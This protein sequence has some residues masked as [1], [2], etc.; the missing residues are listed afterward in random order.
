MIS[1][2]SHPLVLNLKLGFI[3]FSKICY[4][5]HSR[6]FKRYYQIVCFRIK[7]KLLEIS[8]QK[9]TAWQ[10]ESA[11]SSAV[12]SLYR[13]FRYKTSRNSNTVKMSCWF[14]QNL[15]HLI[16]QYKNFVRRE[17]KKIGESF[18]GRKKKAFYLF[19]C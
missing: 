19:G 10:T 1:I 15:F 17:A 16:K 18:R 2:F 4:F 8:T 9:S 12:S 14:Q 6:I 7:L 3:L 13:R 11:T 5:N